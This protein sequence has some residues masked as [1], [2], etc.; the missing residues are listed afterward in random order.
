[1]GEEKKGKFLIPQT[2][3]TCA[4]KS[5]EIIALLR[6]VDQIMQAL[7][8]DLQALLRDVNRRNGI[9]ARTCCGQRKT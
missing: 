1:M 4:A 2:D 5:L 9:A 7:L 8:R 6:D 3:V